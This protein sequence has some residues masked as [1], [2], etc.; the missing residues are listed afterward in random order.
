LRDWADY[1][2]AMLMEI[3]ASR[4]QGAKSGVIAE[5]HGP[6]YEGKS[7]RNAGKT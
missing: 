7:R 3:D 1:Q 5:E 4:L 2:S 6:P